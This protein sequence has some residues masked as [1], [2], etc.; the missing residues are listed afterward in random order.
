MRAVFFG[1][2]K[3]VGARRWARRFAP[4]PVARLRRPRCELCQF[5]FPPISRSKKNPTLVRAVFFDSRKW[6]GREDGHDASRRCLSPAFGGLGQL[7]QF[8]SRQFLDQKKTAH[9]SEGGLFWILENGRG[10]KIRTS[11]P[12][13]PIVVRYQAALRPDRI[14][15]KQGRQ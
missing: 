6:S 4:M 5:H 15:N 2:S 11:D 9:F 8:H 10:E 12:H 14:R 7:C 13:N 3:M 1:F